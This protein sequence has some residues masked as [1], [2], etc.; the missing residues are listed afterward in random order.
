MLEIRR[1]GGDALR[2][3]ED[4]GSD[5]RVVGKLNVVIALHVFAPEEDADR[6][7]EVEIEDSSL[8]FLDRLDG[9]VVEDVPDKKKREF[10][11]LKPSLT[12]SG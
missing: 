10:V 7:H 2:L 4:V 8:V 11:N 5:G 9:E 12:L 1:R 6:S 3:G